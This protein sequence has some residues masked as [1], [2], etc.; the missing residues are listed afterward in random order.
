MSGCL[1]ARRAAHG[2]HVYLLDVTEAV[3]IDW[4]LERGQMTSTRW[5]PRR[6]L[7]QHTR[8]YP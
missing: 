8:S 4:D 1:V 3:L 6:G 7:Q 2:S 5:S